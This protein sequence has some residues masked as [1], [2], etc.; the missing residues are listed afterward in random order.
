[1]TGDRAVEPPPDEAGPCH[2]LVD[3]AT[4][5]GA[6]DCPYGAWRHLVDHAGPHQQ[7]SHRR[8]HRGQ[9]LACQVVLDA[10]VGL[11]HGRGHVCDAEQLRSCAAHTTRP[12]GG[13][14]CNGSD[15]SLVAGQVR[16]PQDGSDLDLVHHQVRVGHPD[17][18][19]RPRRTCAGSGPAPPG[20]ARPAERARG[21]VEHDL[22]LG[23]QPGRGAG[24]E[25][26][27]D[28]RPRLA[29]SQGLTELDQGGDAAG[30][31]GR[32]SGSRRQPGLACV[33]ETSAQEPPHQVG[34]RNT[35]R[36]VEPH[37]PRR[38]R[39]P[40]GPRSD[41]EGLP[42]SGSARRRG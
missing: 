28:D 11:P 42:R 5:V 25:T 12:A 26:V 14:V 19:S 38:R 10:D 6:E 32:P 20:R 21:V 40:S 29:V 22:E 9:D 2:G 23:A 30:A 37:H 24:R 39:R 17:Q 3:Q 15:L 18:L 33:L 36:E 7:A 13:V 8:R 41:T 31:R 27:E 35:P 34:L 16:E 4:G 1:M